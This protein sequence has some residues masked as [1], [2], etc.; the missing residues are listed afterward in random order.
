MNIGIHPKHLIEGVLR[1]S[2][3]PLS[4]WSPSAEILVVGTI[5]HESLGG[6]YL[7]QNG[8]NEEPKGPAMSI[9]GMEEIR[10]RDIIDRSSVYRKLKNQG[11]FEAPVNYRCMV[12]DLK[13]A[14]I[15]CRLSYMLIPEKLPKHNDYPELARYWKE[16]YNTAAGKGVRQDF[17][18]NL[19]NYMRGYK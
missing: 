12:Y 5:A 4:L 10:Y 1:P 19:E 6:Y 13:L 9:A 7:M 16:H 3:K 14:I 8:L 17:V 18:E 15:M 11:L 2:L